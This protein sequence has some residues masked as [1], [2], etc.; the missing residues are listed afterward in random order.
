MTIWGYIVYC[1]FIIVY[2]I[3]ANE[4][5]FTSPLCA[6]HNLK[7]LSVVLLASKCIN[8]LQALAASPDPEDDPA[9]KLFVL[10]I[11]SQKQQAEYKL[12]S[13]REIF[14]NNT[15]T[16]NFPEFDEINSTLYGC[17]AAV[18]AKYP[19]ADEYCLASVDQ[20]VTQTISDSQNE[21]AACSNLTHSWEL[22]STI[23]LV[24]VLTIL[25]ILKEESHLCGQTV[26]C[27]VFARIWKGGSSI[28]SPTD[29]AARNYLFFLFK[30]TLKISPPRKQ[31]I[32][33]L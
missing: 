6:K 23:D 11:Q 8:H 33:N 1:L 13:S 15:K 27:L 14:V 24:L 31:M 22:V 18:K 9:Y 4:E 19:Y 29:C 17:F 2:N 25:Y 26:I 12:N 32:I 7:Y 21:L 5:F 3:N 28:R 30:L 10:Q 20:D 16:F